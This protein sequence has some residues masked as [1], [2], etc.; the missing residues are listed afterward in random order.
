MGV[1]MHNHTYIHAVRPW[2]RESLRQP[3][4]NFQ[5][6]LVTLDKKYQL[7]LQGEG[8]SLFYSDNYKT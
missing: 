5:L 4:L 8:L 2:S 1:D 6:A 3:K 7:Y